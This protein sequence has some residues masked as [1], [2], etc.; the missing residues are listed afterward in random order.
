MHIVEGVGVVIYASN[1]PEDA[2]VDPTMQAC[3]LFK[4]NQRHRRM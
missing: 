2:P 4:G 1:C 3:S